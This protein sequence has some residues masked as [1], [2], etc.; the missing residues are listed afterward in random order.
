[1]LKTKAI[2]W[3]SRRAADTSEK[4]QK[5]N[6]GRGLLIVVIG[7]AVLI[8]SSGLRNV[9][10]DIF[11]GRVIQIVNELN[12]GKSHKG[13]YLRALVTGVESRMAMRS[14]PGESEKW[15]YEKLLSPEE[16]S[17]VKNAWGEHSD[18]DRT[19]FDPAGGFGEQS[20][21]TESRAR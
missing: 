9:A 2:L 16:L 20:S 8:S 21:M 5:C 17:A 11:V 3:L 15:W 7:G 18:S 12:D 19:E 1:M 10:C 14:P 4:F 13:D 6:D